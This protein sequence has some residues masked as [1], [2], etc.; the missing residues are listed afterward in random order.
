[1]LE[2]VNEVNNS[3]SVHPTI[4]QGGN[5]SALGVFCGLRGAVL[6]G[7]EAAEVQSAQP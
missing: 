5:Q 1:M 3:L 2:E 4:E 7:T 6:P